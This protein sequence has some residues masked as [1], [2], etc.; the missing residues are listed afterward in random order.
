MLFGEVVAMVANCVIEFIG[1]IIAPLDP[2][3]I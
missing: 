1:G 3:F 2:L